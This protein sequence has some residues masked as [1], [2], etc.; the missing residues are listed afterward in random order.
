MDLKL[1]GK[2]IILRPLKKSDVPSI[3]KYT[4]T[5][6]IPR[7]TFVPSP[8]TV[9]NI[10]RFINRSRQSAR[11]GTTYVFAIVPHEAGELAGTIGIHAVSAAHK[12]A[13]IGY[14]LAKNF[15]RRGIMPEAL[16]LVLKFCFKKLKLQRV[17]AGTLI[18]N[19]ASQKLLK[20]CGFKFE[21]RHRSY[22]FHRKRIKD[23]YMYAIT[24]EDYRAKRKKKIMR[25]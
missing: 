12:K 14:W 17:Q 1:N 16:G 23:A 22:Y 13:E 15:R 11:K 21:G 5:A 10:E 18:D 9:E 4:K 19:V 7:Y 6:D 3:F 2:T 25:K 24:R 8:N 20:K